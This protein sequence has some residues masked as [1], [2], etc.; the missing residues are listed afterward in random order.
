MVR[1]SANISVEFG[2]D[3]TLSCEAKGYPPPFIT[4]LR[5]LGPIY[6]NPRYTLT[7]Y[8]GHGVLHIADAEISDAGLYY[9]VVVSNLHGSTVI[10]PA[11][12]V[13]V[14]NGELICEF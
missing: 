2:E 14:K 7:S 9:C 8:H 12:S 6:H 1:T 10:Q 4:W 3:I 11:I 13:T 5:D